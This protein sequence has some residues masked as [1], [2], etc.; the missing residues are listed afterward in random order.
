M[1]AIKSSFACKICDVEMALPKNNLD[2]LDFIAI[3]I[4]FYKNHDICEKNDILF[5]QKEEALKKAYESHP[6]KKRK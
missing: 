4:Q 2:M 5:K 1:A 3:L 6:K